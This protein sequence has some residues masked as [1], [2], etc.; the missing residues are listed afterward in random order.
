[1]PW[2]LT[3]SLGICLFGSGLT[4]YPS[5]PQTLG[6]CSEHVPPLGALEF[7]V[8]KHCGMCW[9][10]GQWSKNKTSNKTSTIQGEGLTGD[11]FKTVLFIYR[12]I[13]KH[14]AALI[15]RH[16]NVQCSFPKAT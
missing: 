15:S 14:G 3:I 4:L 16:R 12:Q 9:V 8:A 11:G 7:I 2:A 10:S 6:T 5:W 1:M 13:Y